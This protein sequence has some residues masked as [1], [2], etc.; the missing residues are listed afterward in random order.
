MPNSSTSTDIQIGAGLANGRL[1]LHTW[2]GTTGGPTS[3]PTLL[4]LTLLGPNGV[5][6]AQLTP[7]S[8]AS[9]SVV[10]TAR[11][12]GAILMQDL[13]RAVLQTTSGALV[14]APAVVVQNGPGNGFLFETVEAPNGAGFVSDGTN[15]TS[16]ASSAPSPPALQ[17]QARRV[18]PS[19]WSIWA[20]SAS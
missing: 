15:I 12:I 3:S 10:V 18:S 13:V 8:T 5:S 1:A 9:N 4:D 20:G 2:F 16:T 14:V 19:N 11:V 7:D 17:A 6:G